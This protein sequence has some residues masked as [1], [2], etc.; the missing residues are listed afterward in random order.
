M[1]PQLPQLFC[2]FSTT[3]ASGELFTPFCD[4]QYIFKFKGSTL[5]QR[6]H[7]NLVSISPY[8]ALGKIICNVLDLFECNSNLNEGR[9]Y[10]PNPN[11]LYNDSVYTITDSLTLFFVGVCKMHENTRLIVNII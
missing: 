6:E 7:D 4:G 8:C 5:L 11:K 9:L 10:I 1:S 2:N 3:L